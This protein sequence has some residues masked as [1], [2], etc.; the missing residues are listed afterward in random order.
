MADNNL[1]YLDNIVSE[2]F[3]LVDLFNS[4]ISTDFQVNG[5]PLGIVHFMEQLGKHINDEWENVTKQYFLN[6]LTPTQY[7][8]SKPLNVRPFESDINNIWEDHNTGTI[9]S[10]WNSIGGLIIYDIQ[11]DRPASLSRRAFGNKR[12]LTPRLRAYV[13]LNDIIYPIAV[14]RKE[15]IV[16]FKT[17]GH[18]SKEAFLIK[19]GLEQYIN[20]RRE[21]LFGLGAQQFYIDNGDGETNRDKRTKMYYR[22]INMYLRLE[23]WY[24][25]TGAPPISSV[26]IDFENTVTTE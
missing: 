13:S 17:Y 19:E 18:T 22:T 15:Y 21:V 20:T 11:K 1:I 5:Q 25:G 23:E 6:N 9:D 8:Y 4:K 24:I 2:P 7:L 16:N 26:G 14:Q 3:T 12:E 10:P